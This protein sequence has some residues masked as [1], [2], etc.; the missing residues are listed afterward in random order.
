MDWGFCT[1]SDSRQAREVRPRD[2]F[3]LHENLKSLAHSFR[4]DQGFQH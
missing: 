4:V 2:A 1:G 3:V